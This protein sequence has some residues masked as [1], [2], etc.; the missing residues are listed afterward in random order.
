M[1]NEDRIWVSVCAVALTLSI[2]GIVWL[3]KTGRA[4]KYAW[5]SKDTKQS[6]GCLIQLLLGAPFIVMIGI[7]H[8]YLSPLFKTTNFWNHWIWLYLGLS[9]ACV[10]F[11]RVVNKLIQIAESRIDSTK[12]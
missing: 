1:L 7:S 5:T 3:Q 2:T 9:M 12:K 6:A 4:G 10:I 8:Q 11:N